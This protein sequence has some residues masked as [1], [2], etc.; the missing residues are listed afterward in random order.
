MLKRTEP[1]RLSRISDHADSV[2][3]LP[4]HPDMTSFL[5]V[6][7]RYEGLAVGSLYFT[8]SVPYR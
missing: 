3:L 6:P 8:D 7:I 5:D 2:G 4:G 1:P